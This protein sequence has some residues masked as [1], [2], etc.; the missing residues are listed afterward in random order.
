MRPPR[1]NRLIAASVALLKCRKVP[2]A[3]I[4]KR[5]HLGEATIS[6]L[7][8]DGGE[9]AK[10]IKPPEFDWSMVDAAERAELRSIDDVD[11]VS[12]LLTE[13]LANIPNRLPARLDAT[14]VLTRTRASG[15][16]AH[17]S[18]LPDDFYDGAVRAVW[19]LLTP[20]NVIGITW[21]Q[22]LYEFLKAARKARL[23]ARY[24]DDQQPM[25]IPLCGESLEGTRP[26]TL[27]SSSLT[28]EFGQILTSRPVSD[29]LSLSMIP[30]FLPGPDAFSDEEVRAVRKLLTYSP[31]YTRI[32]GTDPAGNARPLVEQLDIVITSI[33][34]EGRT[35]GV[36]D[37]P[38][39]T[40]KTLQ[41]G[42]FEHLAIG[43]LAGIPLARA[44]A[45]AEDL[46]S[47][48]ERWTG[49]QEKHLRLCAERASAAVNAPAGVIVVGTGRERAACVLEAV[50]RG[51]VNH[52]VVDE[53]LGHALIE[54]LKVESDYPGDDHRKQTVEIDP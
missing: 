16:D 39:F 43:D 48:S 52:V 23:A 25:I 32:F 18:A 47:L 30:V 13:R 53:D 45:S 1:T 49:L 15:D 37:H 38:D 4:A 33:S 6:R 27:S 7:L 21:G 34:R 24:S 40:W 35:F 5:L 17:R 10:Y 12:A 36:G 41:L 9:A 46:A 44:D 14:V 20:A 26:S 8:K 51:L 22:T 19:E 29:Y 28:L 50:R 31:P 11:A 3:A 2:Q 42:A 54:Q